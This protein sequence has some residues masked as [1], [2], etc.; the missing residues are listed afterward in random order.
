[1]TQHNKLAI[2]DRV[3]HAR[4]SVLSAPG[5]VEYVDSD[6]VRVKW[7][8]GQVGLLLW[9]GSTHANARDLIKLAAYRPADV[10]RAG[11]ET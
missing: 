1:M 7:D 9:D 8:D 5:T 11:K 6:H 3:E 2:G 10:S 4:T